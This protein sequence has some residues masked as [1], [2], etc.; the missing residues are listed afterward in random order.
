M[1]GTPVLLFY[2]EPERDSLVPLDR[3]LRRALRP[4]Y[5]RLIGGPAVSGF[6]VWFQSLV[7]AL[8]RT[9]T[10]V[11]V[12][13]QRLARR[14]PA[15]PVGLVGYPLV[16]E[17]YDLPNPAIL[18]PG[19]YDHPSLAPKL[20]E[21]PR[22]RNYLVTCDWMLRLFT[23][24]YGRA[25][26]LWYAGIDLDEWPD[27]R[28]DAK[29]LDVLVYDKIRWNRERQEEVLLRPALDALRARG[30]SHETVRYGAYHHDAFRRSLRRSRAL[31]FLCEHETQGM[32]YQEALASNVPVLAW[33]NG[34]WL[35]PRRPQFESEPVPA[36][37]VPYFSA[38]CGERFRDGGD[39][40]EKLDLFWSRLSS[41]EPRRYVGRELSL[42]GSAKRYLEVYRSLLP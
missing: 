17:G 37:S 1:K 6:L 20:L 39:L 33:D 26:R 25:C 8:R 7:K 29:T 23:P 2:R 3:Y 12:N 41:Y 21:D 11:E 32:A 27:A 24:Y 5:K 35:D 30:L 10:D 40:A 15:Y 9:G 19:L 18:G 38:E 13:N 42:G 16:V 22:F 14:N 4:F 36:S 28:R 34:F 31:L